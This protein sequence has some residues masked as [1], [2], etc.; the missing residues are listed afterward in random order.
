M[1]LALGIY[2]ENDLSHKERSWAISIWYQKSNYYQKRAELLIF[3]IYE[4]LS[5]TK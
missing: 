5:N 4:E 2:F 3:F 1:I